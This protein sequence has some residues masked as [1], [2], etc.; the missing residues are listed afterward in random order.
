MGLIARQ[1]EAAGIPTLC[2]SSA[3]SITRSVNPPRAAF[4]D[5]PLGHT[6]GKPHEP[7][8][9]REILLDALEGFESLREPGSL[10]VLPYEWADDDGWTDPPV[11][12]EADSHRASSSD[13]RRVRTTEPQYQSERDRELAEIALAKGECES[14]VFPGGA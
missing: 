12:T 6:A 5:F 1:I 8:L 3:L 13:E 4:L 2:M 14:C 10:K 11:R 7:G 9:Q